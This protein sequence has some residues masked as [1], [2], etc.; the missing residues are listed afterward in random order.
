MYRIHTY[1]IVYNCKGV[2]GTLN[3]IFSLVQ[4]Q[5]FRKKFSRIV[6]I[7][8]QNKHCVQKVNILK[9]MMTPVSQLVLRYTLTILCMVYYDGK[10]NMSRIKLQAF[11]QTALKIY[12]FI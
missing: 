9:I 1:L 10:G 7:V 3:D 12:F 8:I 2:F 6:F 5:Y 4:V 11:L